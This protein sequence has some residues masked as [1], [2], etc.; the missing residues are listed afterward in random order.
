MCKWSLIVYCT[1][2]TSFPIVSG[3][4]FLS[5]QGSG[6]EFTQKVGDE[7]EVTKTF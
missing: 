1:T 5:Q 4:E 6:I 2:T 3:Q 7:S